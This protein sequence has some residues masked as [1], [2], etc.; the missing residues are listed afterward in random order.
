MA[1]TAELR[2]IPFISAF[3]AIPEDGMEKAPPAGTAK[4]AELLLALEAVEKTVRTYLQFHTRDL[5]PFSQNFRELHVCAMNLGL[6]E[7]TYKLTLEEAGVWKLHPL[8]PPHP[9]AGGTFQKAVFAQ[10][11]A[12][13]EEGT[14]NSLVSCNGMW[15]RSRP[16]ASGGGAT[17]RKTVPGV[18]SSKGIGARSR[19]GTGSGGDTFQVRLQLSGIPN[20][21]CDYT[22]RG[23]QCPRVNC[24]FAHNQVSSTAAAAPVP[25][26][27]NM[28]LPPPLVPSPS[29]APAA[30]ERCSAATT[31]TTWRRNR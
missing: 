20:G 2:F 28:L 17:K 6:E 14:A 8:T 3:M 21:A 23:L 31:P 12:L 29:A 4:V 13:V 27:Q 11:L 19:T 25:Q 18:S 24:P 30:P 1:L 5:A 9:D 15:A 7:A 22:W 16:P 26:A 10:L